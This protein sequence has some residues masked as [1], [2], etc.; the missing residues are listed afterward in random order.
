MVSRETQNFVQKALP[1]D[2]KILYIPKGSMI[3]T[4]LPK[5]PLERV[6]TNL[7]E[8]QVMAMGNC[9]EICFTCH[10]ILHT[11]INDNSPQHDST[12]IKEFVSQ[13]GFDHV[14]TSPYFPE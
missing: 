3:A 1:E 14:T 9:N 11:I 10:G 13:Y 12:E 4:L 7:F 6:K 8:L 2:I 5:H